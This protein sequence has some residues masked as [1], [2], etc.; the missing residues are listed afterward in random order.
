MDARYDLFP[1]PR[2][3]SN[4]LDSPNPVR[5]LLVR[6][7]EFIERCLDP[8]NSS[9]FHDAD[10]NLGIGIN[11]LESHSNSHNHD[12]SQL[13]VIVIVNQDENIINYYDQDLDDHHKNDNSH[14]HGE[15]DLDDQTSLA[16]RGVRTGERLHVRGLFGRH[17]L[18][19]LTQPLYPVLA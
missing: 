10:S 1:T 8:S 2:D 6:H 4:I 17:V 14:D 3:I 13:I 5:N 19:R 16:K 9:S 15:P 11:Y 7:D 12:N 18:Q